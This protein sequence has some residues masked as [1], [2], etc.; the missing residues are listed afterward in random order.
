MA[1][2]ARACRLRSITIAAS[3]GGDSGGHG[4]VAG[5]IIEIRQ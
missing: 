3:L 1:V 4:C 5:G 2:A